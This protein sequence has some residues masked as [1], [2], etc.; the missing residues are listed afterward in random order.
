ME[1]NQCGDLETLEKIDIDMN[2]ENHEAIT[3]VQYFATEMKKWEEN[4]AEREKNCDAGRMSYSDA[5]SLG[6]TEYMGIFQKYCDPTQAKPRDYYFSMPPEYNPSAIQVV[7]VECLA[8][9]EVLIQTKERTPFEMLFKYRLE[10]SVGRWRIVQKHSCIENG[11][12]R[13][14]AL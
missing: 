14:I 1:L 10:K 7:G 4:C 13:E 8:D 9:D 2:E 11:D 3:T 12:D 5:E 6:M